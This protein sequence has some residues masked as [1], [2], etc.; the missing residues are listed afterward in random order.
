MFSINSVRLRVRPRGHFFESV[1]IHYHHVDRLDAMR[2]Q[3]LHVLGLA[4]HRQDSAGHVGV[5]GFHAA[6][7]H[8]GEAGHFI[9][10]A[11]RHAGIAQQPSRAA[12]GDQFSAQIVQLA[13]KRRDAGFIGDADQDALDF[14]HQSKGNTASGGLDKT[15]SHQSPVNSHLLDRPGGLSYSAGGEMMNNVP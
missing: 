6:V 14:G 13:G 15:T 2:R 12:G 11:H 4:A 10:V 8:F 3:R 5:H 7:Q 1:Q 9:D